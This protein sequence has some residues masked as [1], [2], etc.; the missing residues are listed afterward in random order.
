MDYA[1]RVL[2]WSDIL[3]EQYGL[4]PGEFDGKYETFVSLLHPEDRTATLDTI[5]KAMVNGEDFS[6]EHRT[7]WRDGTVRWLRGV[8]RFYLSPAG[9]PVR[10]VGISIDV[11]SRHVLEEQVPP[12]AE[13]GRDRPDGR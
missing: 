1:T 6:T 2:R 8:G 7:T 3:Q 4:T 5:G 11:T 12:I 10:A 9:E 13:D